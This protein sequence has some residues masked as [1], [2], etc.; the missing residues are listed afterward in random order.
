MRPAGLELVPNEAQAKHPAAEGI[1]V[2]VCLGAAIASCA[3]TK[4]LVTD[5]KAQ[6]Q[7]RP[8]FAGVQG[9]ITTTPDTDRYDCLHILKVSSAIK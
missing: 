4:R 3:L 6:H 1:L 9:S 2:I 7:I 5:R 8:N